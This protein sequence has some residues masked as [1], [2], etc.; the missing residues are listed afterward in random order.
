M[1]PDIAAL[2]DRIDDVTLEM[3]RLLKDRSDIARQ[4]GRLKQEGG[5]GIT[6]EAREES[7]RGKVASLCRYTGADPVSAARLLNLLLGESVRAQSADGA[8]ATHLSVFLRAKSLEEQGRRIIHMEVG[9]PDFAPPPAAGVALGEALDR[10][11]TKYGQAAGMPELRRGLARHA[12]E[13]FGAAGLSGDNIVVAP[14]ARFAI[15]AAITTL[16]VPGDEMVVIEPAWPAYRD[17]AAHAGVKVRAVSTTLEGGWEPS[18]PQVE[19]AMGPNTKMIVLNYPNNPT[20][21]VLG[22]PLLDGIMDLARARGLYVLSD[23]IYSQYAAPSPGWKSVLGYGYDRSI[24][25]QSFSK[26][27]AMTGFRIGY[28]VA[29]A[30]VARRMARLAALC[31]T[32]VSAPVQYAALRAL[33]ADTSGNA[34]TIR[35]RLDAL[36]REAGAVPGLEFARPDGAMYV[37]ARARRPGFDGARFAE[38]ALERG[39]AVA[40]GEGFGGGYRDFIRISACQNKKT[41]ME[42]M[43]I[44]SDTMR[45]AYP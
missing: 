31:L 24:V 2:R 34:R 37:F 43:G 41:L 44:L 1:T 7:L 15:F 39:L 12:S 4:I 25:T 33:G 28:A 11:H 6:D 10:G 5:R 30:A 16:L 20:G 13:A 45:S 8:P 9:E 22:A 14:G 36:C 42:G 35:D 27:H 23:E 3:V 17:C 19:G 32:S 40:P 26:S 18:L 21:K 38:A 29:E